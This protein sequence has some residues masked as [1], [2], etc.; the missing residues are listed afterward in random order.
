VWSYDFVFDQ[1]EGGRGLKWLVVLDEYTPE[2]L[3]LEVEHAMVK[4]SRSPFCSP[5][6]VASETS[7]GVDPS[8]IGC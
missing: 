2:C 6:V 4:P 3:A 5:S 8:M 7:G 1:T